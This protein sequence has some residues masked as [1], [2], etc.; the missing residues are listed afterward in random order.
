MRSFSHARTHSFT[1]ALT[2]SRI[3]SSSALMHALEKCCRP[4]GA[5]P[6]G[7]TKSKTLLPPCLPTIGCQCSVAH[8]GSP[9]Y[10]F[11]F[12]LSDDKGL[13]CVTFLVG[14]KCPHSSNKNNK[15]Q[16]FHF[17]VEGTCRRH[18]LMNIPALHAF[19]TKVR[20]WNPSQSKTM[21]KLHMATI[22][23]SLA[24]RYGAELH[25]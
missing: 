12:A 1:H 18:G 16:C 13:K 9:C 2:H 10:H 22:G 5:V 17:M 19:L 21:S 14:V 23:S 7:R 25:S 4:C 11:Q 3:H 15:V 20:V 8:W 24:S 6:C